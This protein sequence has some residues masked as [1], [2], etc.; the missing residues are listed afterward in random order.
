MV[1]HSQIVLNTLMGALAEAFYTR[2]RPLVP[3]YHPTECHGG[4]LRPVGGEVYL[5][6]KTAGAPRAVE[7]CPWVN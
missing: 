3:V 5:P 6:L 4:E 2:G 7:A 1:S